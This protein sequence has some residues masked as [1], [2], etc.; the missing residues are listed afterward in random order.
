M[1]KSHSLGERNRASGYQ[2]WSAKKK[3]TGLQPIIFADNSLRPCVPQVYQ[4]IKANKRIL[5][6]SMLV[7]GI[8]NIAS[9]QEEA[10]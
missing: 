5:R 8:T 3:K 4:I 2:D 10:F 9:L 7:I 1:T 6:K